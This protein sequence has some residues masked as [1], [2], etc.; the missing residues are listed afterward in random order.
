MPLHALKDPAN[1]T[2]STWK[3]WPGKV[4]L[5]EIHSPPVSSV[6]LPGD[7]H[8]CSTLPPDVTGVMEFPTSILMA[9]DS[10]DRLGAF[11][12][13]ERTAR[14]GPHDQANSVRWP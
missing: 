11:P 1:P 2:A 12:V 6:D 13:S 3:E 10:I 4:T 5:K 7:E 8:V 14:V 9:I